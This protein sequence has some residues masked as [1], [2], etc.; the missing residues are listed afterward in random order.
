MILARRIFFFS[1]AGVLVGVALA[2]WQR[3]GL[4]FRLFFLGLGLAFVALGYYYRSSK[5]LYLISALLLGL[6][7]GAWRVSLVPAFDYARCDVGQVTLVG[8]VVSESSET[9]FSRRA[10]FV[11]TGWTENLLLSAPRDTNLNYG[12]R[13]EISGRLSR[14]KNFQTN[15]GREFD[16]VR[17]LAKDNILCLLEAK[18]IRK[19][20]SSPSLISPFFR[21]KNSFLSAL[22]KALPEPESTLLG[23]LVLGGKNGLDQDLKQAYTTTGL[24]HILV[25]SGYNISLVAA[26]LTGV[27]LMFGSLLSF[28]FT[29]L[30]LSLFVF[31]AGG[32]AAAVRAGIMGVIAV[33]ARSLGR[34]NSAGLPLLLAAVVMVWLNPR[35]LNFDLGF[36]LSFLATLGI[37][38]GPAMFKPLVEKILQPG[39]WSETLVVTLGA[40]VFTWPWLAYATGQVSL[41]ALPA[42]LLVVPMVSPLMWFGL[43]LGAIGILFTLPALVLAWPIYLVLALQIWL[44]RFLAKIPLASISV[45]QFSLLWLII[46]YGP[47]IYWAVKAN[48]KIYTKSHADH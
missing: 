33:L 12:D 18:Q 4:S 21:L 16:Y 22:G 38:Y 39:F 14:P 10:T 25:L 30:G 32:G 7:L 35:L 13:L 37:V 31:V 19:L 1:L 43:L 3:V 44:V 26:A 36:Q 9:N 48:K 42:N 27:S 24:S 41:V 46:F 17:Y 11:S 20:D 47:I 8:Q 23:G 40:L 28:I 45:E 2:N 5:W 34:P 29:S 15:Q 6:A